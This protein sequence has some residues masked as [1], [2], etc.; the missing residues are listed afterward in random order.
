MI[1]TKSESD[2]TSLDLSSPRSPKRPVYYVQSPSRDSHDE[3]KS[4]SVQATPISNSPMDSPSHPSYS[5]HSRTSSASRVSGTFRSPSSGRKGSNKRSLE[6]GWRE[7]NVIE[8]EGDYDEFYRDQ[9]FS[10]RCQVFLG[11]AG[12]VALFTLFCFILWCASTPYKAKIAVKV[13]IFSSS[14]FSLPLLV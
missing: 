9:G 2:V 11:M 7:C 12:F 1:H 13:S 6:K 14:L 10:R 4:S 5:R 3:D 8:E